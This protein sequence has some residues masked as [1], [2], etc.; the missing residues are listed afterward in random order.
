M[1]LYEKVRNFIKRKINKVIIVSYVLWDSKFFLKK[2]DKVLFVD[3]G[4]NL[5]QGY[6]FFSKF[7]IDKNIDFELF[8]PN[9]FCFEKLKNL[10]SEKQQNIQIWNIGVG[11]KNERVNLYGLNNENKYSQG[12]SILIEHNSIFLK[13]IPDD[14]IEV[15]LIDFSNYLIEK[16]K[17]YNKIIVKMDIE[18]AEIKILEKL[19]E[20]NLLDL[21]KILYV[22]FHA[23]YQKKFNQKLTK[24]REH[25]IIKALKSKKHLF[26]RIWQ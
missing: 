11:T 7:F 17:I 22:E 13:R 5:G 3:L 9:P 4:A 6:N 15:D 16:S 12:A 8:E 18:G 14:F 10:K 24:Q 26:L 1:I 23:K 2:S 19:I 20:L 21:I 25:K